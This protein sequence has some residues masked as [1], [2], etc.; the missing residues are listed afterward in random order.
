MVYVNTWMWMKSKRKLKERHLRE[1]IYELHYA[2][3]LLPVFASAYELLLPTPGYS[4]FGLNSPSAPPLR[5]PAMDSPAHG[6]EKPLSQGPM[7]VQ[8]DS[9]C[10]HSALKEL[11][12][13]LRTDDLQTNF[14]AVYRRESED[15]DRDYV[16]KYDEPANCHIRTCATYTPTHRPSPPRNPDDLQ[17]RRS[18]G[19]ERRRRRPLCAREWEPGG[20][21]ENEASIA[22]ALDKKRGIRVMFK[23]SSQ[24]D[25]QREVDIYKQLVG[26]VGLP[27]IFG[28]CLFSPSFSYMSMELFTRDLYHYIQDHGPMCL[29]QACK[30]AETVLSVLS[31]A[32]SNLIIHC[33]IKPQNIVCSPDANGVG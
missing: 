7:V 12:D 23:I 20:I 16:G 3:I 29:R 18:K 5:S 22:Q 14:F 6:G 31:S 9:K 27:L 15:F 8:I 1:L 28:W 2:N 30:V 25:I 24:D 21:P 33:D 10:L 17:L 19:V 13:P 4:A 26:M 11:F 32:H